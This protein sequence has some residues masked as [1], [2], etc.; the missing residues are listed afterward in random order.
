MDSSW[1]L[2]TFLQKIGNLLSKDWKF[3]LW[4]LEVFFSRRLEI[5]F[6]QN[7]KP[8]NIRR[9]RN[10]FPED[11]IFFFSDDRTSSFRIL[12]IF[13]LKFGN[14]HFGY[15]ISFSDWKSCFLRLKILYLNI[16]SHFSEDWKSSFR[17]FEIFQ[18]VWNLYSKDSKSS[19]RS[20]DIFPVRLNFFCQED[21]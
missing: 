8:S 18:K 15:W 10:F 17:K 20:L 19:L 5:F 11:W 13:S 3:S 14:V 6:P 2:N 16:W 4:R 21:L 9:S 7:W 12:E 1:R